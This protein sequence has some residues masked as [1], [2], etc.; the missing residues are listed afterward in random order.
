MYGAVSHNPSMNTLTDQ[1]V[2]VVGASSGIGL[3]TARAAAGQGAHVIMISRSAAKLEQ[4][5]HGVAGVVRHIAMDMLDPA[6][7]ERTFATLGTI[8]HLVMT[9]VANE[10]QFFGP[11]TTLTREQIEG[12]LDKLRGF[13]MVTRAAATHMA[14]RGSIG[15]VSGAGAVKPPRGT[16]LTAIAN[17]GVVSLG[18]AL[19]IELAP[20]RV[21]VVMPGVIDTDIHGDK[22]Q[23]I[24]QWAESDALPARRFGQPDDVAN[25]IL[26]LMSNPY[27]TGHTLVVDGGYLLT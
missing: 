1:T 13:L 23:A 18:R 6:A 15:L 24:K 9:A 21:N 7:V 25:A 14:A 27:V 10:Y 2:A 16:A 26:F 3:A 11:I 8:D 22:R 20:V 19:A 5:A 4:A 12:S 17:A